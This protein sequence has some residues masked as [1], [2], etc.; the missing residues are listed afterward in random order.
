MRRPGR[1]DPKG[2]A[3]LT[4]LLSVALIASLASTA[5]WQQWRLTEVETSE[6]ARLQAQWV[7]N[8]ALDWGR[9]ILREDG[10]QPGIDHLGE[11]WSVPLKDARLASFLAADK[12]VQPDALMSEAFLAGQ[13][14]D[15]QGRLN[16]RNLVE[17]GKV[18]SEGL[19][20]FQ[21]LFE[22]LDLPPQELQTLALG[23]RAALGT[24]DALAPLLPQRVEQLGWLGLSANSVARLAPFVNWLPE[25]TKVNLNTASAEVISASTPALSLAQARQWVEDRRRQPWK[26]IEEANKDMGGRP[27]FRDEQHAVSSSYFLISGQMRQGPNLLQ[28]QALVHRQ[29][30]KVALLWRDVKALPPE[31]LSALLR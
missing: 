19:Q 22:L 13:I 30:V 5:L 11:P 15:Q 28:S 25:R 1:A 7:L 2:A 14:T 12:T 9:L 23:L 6:R 26:S 10:R 8:G 24:D 29:G 3:L 21:R 18:S 31:E 20:A 27:V 17:G 16:V 4:A